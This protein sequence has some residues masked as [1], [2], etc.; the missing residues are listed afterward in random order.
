MKYNIIIALF[1][2]FGIINIQA[3]S[4]EELINEAIENNLELKI[5][6]QEY[7][8]ALE[9]SPQI[10]RLPDPEIGM[11]VFPLPVETRLGA[12][13]LR[14]SASQMIPWKSTIN[15]KKD[16]EN[17]KAKALY[18]KINVRILE[19]SYEIKKAY[20]ELY[21]IKESQIIIQR[22][23]E[24][25]ESLEKLALIKVE[26]GK[27]SAADVLGVKMEIEELNQKIKILKN[28]EKEPTISINQLLNRDLNI[29]III[30][31]KLSIAVL[32]TKKDTIISNISS[33]HPMLKMFEL[34]QNISKEAIKL[35][36]LN[37]KPTFGVGMDYMMLT[38]R[39]DANPS[40]NGR[41]IVQVK[42]MMT[43]PIYKQKYRAKENEE[44]IKIN[45]LE[46]KKEELKSRFQAMIEKAY[47]QHETALLEKE[48]YEKQIGII[49]SSINILES[50]YSS[51][52]KNFD[53]LLRLEKVLI[54][55][56]LK[57]LKAIVNSHFAKNNVDRFF[58]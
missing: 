28:K 31:D 54:N 21:E 14:L 57:I 23:M 4:L 1:L 33:N 48:L 47:A 51:K 56:D 15:G 2:F 25:L 49:E 42:A 53:E 35:N 38:K 27:S 22:N 24:I 5:I 39:N 3:Q 6:E 7:L 44:N 37:K 8:S 52:G 36:Q 13:Y 43:I 34:Q 20:Y 45:A 18:E 32:S 41:D 58:L 12:Q 30:K 40:G 55:Y 46:L 16:L 29:P 50:E 17:A 19:L 26:I 9:R 10:S 11:G